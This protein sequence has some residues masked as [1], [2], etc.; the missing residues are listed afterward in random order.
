MN[1]IMLTFVK[2]LCLLFACSREFLH[3]LKKKGGVP[4]ILLSFF[5]GM[6]MKMDEKVGTVNLQG[7]KSEKKREIKKLFFFRKVRSFLFNNV[8]TIYPGKRKEGGQ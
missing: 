6:N 8:R 3:P 4:E 5:K 1:G 7:K 2:C